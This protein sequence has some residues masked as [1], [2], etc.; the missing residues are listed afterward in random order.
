MSQI[1]SVLQNVVTL[2]FVLSSMLA[3]GLSLTIPQIVT[4]LRNVRLVAMALVA[5]FLI[6]P[7]VAYLLTRVI[8]MAQPLQI[9]VLL[10][11]TAAGAPFL[12]KLTSIAKG[13]LAFAAGLMTLLLVVTVFYLPIVLPLLLPGVK[14]SAGQIALSLLASMLLPLGIGLLV[15]A[16]Y[17]EFAAQFQPTMSQASSL[18]LILLLVLMLGLN[19]RNVIALFGSGGLLAVLLLSGIGA[20]AGYLLGGPGSD[21]RRVLALGTGQRN[22]AAAFIVATGNFAAFP[23]VLILLAA[24][25]LV[26]MLVMMPLAGEFGRRAQA[27]GQA[28]VPAGPAPTPANPATPATP[29]TSPVGPV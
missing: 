24:A 23:D 3:T 13:N 11:G 7:G 6:A 5:N 26:Q 10:L 25:G 28:P 27:A 18:S 16:R 8:P 9:G 21:T 15:K 14:V 22:L 20:A 29:P 19:I 17:P 1:V 12:P 4:P 2:A